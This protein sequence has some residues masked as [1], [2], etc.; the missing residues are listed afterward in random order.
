MMLPDDVHARACEKMLSLIP[1][2]WISLAE[3]FIAFPL[4][5]ASIMADILKDLQNRGLIE[6]RMN[7]KTIEA[8]R[9]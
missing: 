6:T 9:I 1:M 5:S 3:V 8:K 2:T 7:G 4:K